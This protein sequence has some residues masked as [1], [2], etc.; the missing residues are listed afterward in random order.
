LRG[1]IGELDLTLD[2]MIPPGSIVLIDT[3]KLEISPKNDWTHEFQRPIYFLRTKDG[4]FC[5]WCELDKGSQWLN[6]NPHPLSTA[7][8]R[9]WKYQTEIENLG[10]VM[11]VVIRLEE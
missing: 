10:R 3:R 7:L 2:P 11:T 9:S 5:G 6:L 8:S 1:I 4:Y